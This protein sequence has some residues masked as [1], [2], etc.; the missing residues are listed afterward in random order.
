[1]TYRLPPLR[2][3][4][5]SGRRPGSLLES[6]CSVPT[7]CDANIEPLAFDA[8]SR[9][10]SSMVQIAVLTEGLLGAL[11]SSRAQRRLRVSVMLGLPGR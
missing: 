9:L 11:A 10:N 3:G 1:M 8:C 2:C 6:R 7:V 5:I 4:S